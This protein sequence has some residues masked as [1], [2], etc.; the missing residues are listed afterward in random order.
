MLDLHEVI[1][2]EVR[3]RRMRTAKGL[4]LAGNPCLYK[5]TYTESPTARQGCPEHWAS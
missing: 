5:R 4:S 1:L 2:S 3:E